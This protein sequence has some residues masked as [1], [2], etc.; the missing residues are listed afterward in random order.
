M[1][2]LVLVTKKDSATKAFDTSNYFK[3]TEDAV[4][5]HTGRDDR[6]NWGIASEKILRIADD[7][8]SEYKIVGPEPI[9]MVTIEIFE[10]LDHS[11]EAPEPDYI[12]LVECPNCGGHGKH[13]APKGYSG[14]PHTCAV[15]AGKGK[16]IAPRYPFNPGKLSPPK[17]RSSMKE[18]KRCCRKKDFRVAKHGPYKNTRGEEVM[19]L[20]CLACGYATEVAW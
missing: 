12:P 1:P 20:Q 17:V 8:E 18:G 13:T 6:H 7:F 10:Y 5:E 19:L 9:P 4:S 14:G 15:C 16:V 2:P 11:G 3:L